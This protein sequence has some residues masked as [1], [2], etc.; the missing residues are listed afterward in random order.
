MNFTPFRGFYLG[1]ESGNWLQKEWSGIF[2][3]KGGFEGEYGIFYFNKV[4]I[5]S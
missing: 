1:S 2:C 3:Q 5:F 4:I